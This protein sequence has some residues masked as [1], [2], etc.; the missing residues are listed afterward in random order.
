[1]A[2]KRKVK[3]PVE[4]EK[5]KSEKEKDTVERAIELKALVDKAYKELLP[6]SKATVDLI[7]RKRSAA[8]LYVES[9][10]SKQEQ[11]NVFIKRDSET[12]TVYVEKVAQRLADYYIEGG[13]RDI[14]SMVA[15]EFI[16]MASCDLVP[17]STGTCNL[18]KKT[19]S[20][21]I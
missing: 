10:K 11:T 13:L 15:N 16:F 14:V 3:E 2:P 7:V 12:P 8:E 5:D 21:K 17:I 1:M 9:I 6:S 20:L 18:S 4:K 19:C